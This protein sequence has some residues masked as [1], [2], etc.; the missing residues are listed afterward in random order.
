MRRLVWLLLLLTACDPSTGGDAGPDATA[1]GGS[2]A[3]RDAGVAEFGAEAGASRY[4]FVGEEVLLDASGSVGATRFVWR[5]GVGDDIEAQRARVR[6]DAPG[7]Y[8]AVLEVYDEL[9]RRR[10]DSVLI[11]VTEPVTHTPEQSGTLAV[12]PAR[13][14]VAVVVPD[15]NALVV[16]RYAEV[17]EVVARFALPAAPRRVAV[18]GDRWVVS[19]PDVDAVYAIDP[20]GAEELTPLVFAP[21]SRPF[22]VLGGDSLYV[23]LSGTGELAQ[24]DGSLSVVATFEAVTDARDAALLPDG[25]VAVSRWRSPDDGGVIVAVDPESGARSEFR[26][27]VDP[28]A[29]SDTESGGVPNYLTGLLVSPTGRSAVMPSQQAALGEGLFV[30][31][32]PL[33]HETTVRAVMSFLDPAS[34]EED[35]EQRKQFDDRGMASAGVMTERG[36]YLYVAMRGARSVER[37][38]LLSGVQ[39]GTILNVGAALTGVALSPDGRFLFVDASLSRELV[40]YD[41]EDATALPTEVARV[42]TVE[43]EPLSAEL[44]RGAVLFNDSADPRLGRDSYI[45]CAHCHLDGL[46]DHRTWDFT[47][48]G[49][50]LRNTID[51]LG[52]AGLGHGPLHWSANFDEV[53]DFEHDLRGPF[54]GTGLID[55]EVL[56]VGTRS[57]TLGD[58]KAGLSADLDALSAY[59][60]SF[61]TH[62]SSPHREPDGSLTDGAERGRATFSTAGCGGCHSGP[63]LTDSALVDGVPILH[64]VGTLAPGS[65]QRLGAALTGLDTP[66]LHGLFHSAPYLHDGSAAT[67]RDVLVTRNPEDRHG[68]TST[69]SPAELDDLEAYLLSLD[70]RAE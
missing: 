19:C 43:T 60:S 28:Q 33:T 47:D 67:L 1:D 52:R 29:G 39:S 10:T 54:R 3:G 22:G 45:A 61:D 62:L 36:D 63:A 16:V 35:F 57:E 68:T 38:D 30:S 56:A 20:S 37:L 51:L 2:D 41:V 66:T 5:P 59:V 27:A 34:G 69:L 32:R 17:P 21:G 65:G 8:R 46:S 6:Y 42:P 4:A 25:R 48:R 44:L 24:V 40:V 26:L 7:R 14:E 13:D 55:D 50:G 15:D 9:G 53:Q 11:S 31:D 64:D 49:E 70:G 58:P 12:W 18:S 23:A